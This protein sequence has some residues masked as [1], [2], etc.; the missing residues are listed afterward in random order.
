MIVIMYIGARLLHKLPIKILKSYLDRALRETWHYSAFFDMLCTVYIYILV[1]SLVQ[2]L[3]FDFDD[4]LEN[5]VVNYSLHFIF[6]F[7]CFFI[8]FAMFSFLHRLK[9]LKSNKDMQTKIST[10]VGGLSLY[11]ENERSMID[12]P[13]KIDVAKVDQISGK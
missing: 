9:N 6:T 2:F 7:L 12:L 5:C 11:N 8:P 4:K 10:I 3:N 1:S 13:E